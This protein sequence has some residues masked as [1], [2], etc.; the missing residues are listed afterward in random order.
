MAGLLNVRTVN[1]IREWMPYK[2]MIFIF[3]K[4]LDSSE[5]KYVGIGKKRKE[6][7]RK[8]GKRKGNNVICVIFRN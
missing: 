1:I 7:K 4:L 3:T 8:R 5:K 6:K 2:F